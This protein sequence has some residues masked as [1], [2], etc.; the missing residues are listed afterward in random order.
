MLLGKRWFY[1]IKHVPLKNRRIPSL[2]HHA[3]YLGMCGG[4]GDASG[5]EV[6]RFVPPGTST[7]CYL[8]PKAMGPTDH[9]LKSTRALC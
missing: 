6:S 5:P 4:G 2:A 7:M 8:W 9:E 1:A 3:F